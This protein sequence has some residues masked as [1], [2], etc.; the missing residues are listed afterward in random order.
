MRA[1]VL[2]RPIDHSLSPVLHRAAYAALGLDSWS[3]DPIECGVEDLADL[4][5]ERV[6][7]WAGFSCTM[8]LKRVALEIADEVD[9]LAELVGAANTLLPRQAGGWAATTTD[10]AGI[11][12]ALA[13]SGVQP[14]TATLLG[15]GGTAQSALAACAGLRLTHVGVLV[16]D[17]ARTEELADTGRRFGME[18]EFDLLDPD[19]T[20][21][22]ADLIV[23]T[24]PVG[25]ADALAV[26]KWRPQQ[27]VLDVS[28]H[29][30]PSVLAAAA[31]EAGAGVVSG[32]R[33]LLHQAARQVEL[34][35]GHRAPVEAMRSAL[36]AAAPGCGA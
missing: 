35:T 9:E 16:R 14:S 8:P 18:L 31:Q 6:D 28:Y 17:L 4:L 29:P 33:M 22:D 5:A 1:A 2:G 32:A 25:A 21:L 15:A 27:T 26:R 23:S 30:W 19:A 3:Y 10:V 20:A 13:E 34:M 36:L 11:V 7:G 24:L 12:S